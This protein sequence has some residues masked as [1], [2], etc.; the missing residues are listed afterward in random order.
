PRPSSRPCSGSTPTAARPGGVGTSRRSGRAREAW[1]RLGP[2]PDDPRRWQ[3]HRGLTGPGP[4]PIDQYE[5]DE[6]TSP[7][8]LGPSAQYVRKAI[9]DLRKCTLPSPNRKLAPPGWL[10]FAFW[11]CP[12][13]AFEFGARPRRAHQP[14]R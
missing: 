5:A 9:D 10:L 14:N 8:A 3:G 11:Y 12:S 7:P 6:M 13:E 1:T 4:R 2:R